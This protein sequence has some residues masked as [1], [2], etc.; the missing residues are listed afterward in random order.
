MSCGFTRQVF[1]LAGLL[2]ACLAGATA[3]ALAGAQTRPPSPISVTIWGASA[4]AIP[5]KGSQSHSFTARFWSAGSEVSGQRPL[6]WSLK[7]PKAGVTLQPRSGVLTVS[8]G[9]APG[10]CT[11]VAT[12]G[13]VTATHTVQIDRY[14]MTRF[15]STDDTGLTLAV[16]DNQITLR[17]LENP[18]T[19]WDWINGT[20]GNGAAIVPFVGVASAAAPDW[21]FQGATK[22]AGNG[23]KL[24]LRFTSTT[25]RLEM[26]SLWWARPGGG[27]IENWVTVDNRSG[28]PVVFS[29]QPA[30]QLALRARNPVSAFYSD[31]TNV[32]VG[33][34]HRDLIGP[35]SSVGLGREQIPLVFLDENG[36][37]G[38]YLGYEWEMGGLSVSGGADA[39]TL[40]ASARPV[41]EN[42][43]RQAGETFTVPSVYYGTYVGDVDDGGNRF[44][45]WFWNYKITRSLHDNPDEPWT[46][47]CVGNGGN[48]STG[49][50]PQSYYD[51]IAATG[52][53]CVK[54]DFWDGTG[55]CWYT[56]RDWTFH[57]AVWPNGFD[58][59]Q[60]AHRAGLKASL[61][62]GGTYN[63]CDLSTRAGRDSELAA[64]RER[65]DKGWFD[66]WRTDWYT[67]PEPPIPDT[68]EGVTNFLSLQDALI[69]Q[70]PGYRYENCSNGGRYKGFAI[71]RRMTFC[72]MNDQPD[73]PW[74]TRSTYYSNSF[75][76]NPVQL[77]SDL[78]GP[79]DA[80]FYRTDM[81]GAIL[82]IEEHSDTYKQHL[83]LYK[84]RQRPILR[85]ADVY[86][87]LPMPDGV[88]WDGVEYWNES[89]GKGSVFLFKPSTKAV[90]GDSKVI[91]LRGLKGTSRYQ[92]TF[93]DRPNLNCVMTGFALMTQGIS[94][95]GMTGNNASE[96][97]WITG[98]AVQ[99]RP[100]KNRK[101]QGSLLSHAPRTMP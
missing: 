58:Y 4:L 77:K 47:A 45:K 62:M 85:G 101:P 1:A 51:S 22:E 16:K 54:F 63:D 5:A 30:A 64:V 73:T 60:K 42:V 49:S 18:M 82:T 71:C 41:T 39:R 78:G 3:S 70:H 80:Y 57:P 14:R 23:T 7:T 11:L 84:T 37:Q 10:S 24:T 35:S 38:L 98:P 8:A 81:L 46:E 12:T 2:L 99:K 40:T 13:A 27:P 44:K 9:A 90:D 29:P 43:T 15:L 88:N 61:Y 74:I 89:I 56:N 26:R 100:V 19:G 96:I 76:I 32:G 36:V 72:T 55:Q 67:A 69:A 86:H 28:G 83:L 48:A 93:Q 6:L 34:V 25:P 94:V 75:A 91:K 79:D 68:Y 65:Y 50:T 53:E 66:V 21:T 92:L 87:I 52:V 20:Q 97:V 59:A 17:S 33:K 95:T 31:K